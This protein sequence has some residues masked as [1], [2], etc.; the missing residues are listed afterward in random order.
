VWAEKKSMKIEEEDLKKK[1]EAQ[2]EEEKK[3]QDGSVVFPEI[4]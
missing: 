2:A 3:M 1:L 4:H